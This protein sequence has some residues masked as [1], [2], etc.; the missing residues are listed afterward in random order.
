[1]VI[2]EGGV[3]EEESAWFEGEVRFKPLNL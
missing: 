3:W 2:E 1:M